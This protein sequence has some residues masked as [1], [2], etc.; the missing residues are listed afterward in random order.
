MNLLVK[1][2]IFILVKKLLNAFEI[3]TATDGAEN[4]RLSFSVPLNL[5]D[6]RNVRSLG[7][8]E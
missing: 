8:P 1:L 5:I 3:P 2:D 4:I 6:P 7:L